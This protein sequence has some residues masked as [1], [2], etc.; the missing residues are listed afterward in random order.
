M[1]V[2]LNG[3]WGA[4]INGQQIVMQIQG[5]QYQ[6]WMNGMPY[7]TG[8]FQIQGNIL[9]GQTSMGEF[10]SHYLLVNPNGREFMLTDMQTGLAVVYQRMQ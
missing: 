3:V 6:M 1:P 9:Q 7:Q 5:N 4:Y 2:G 8:L 10:F